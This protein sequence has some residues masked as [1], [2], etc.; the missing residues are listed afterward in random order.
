MDKIAKTSADFLMLF[1]KTGENELDLDALKT[2]K[3]AYKKMRF[4]HKQLKVVICNNTDEG[5]KFL[6]GDF[7]ID[8]FPSIRIINLVGDLP[9]INPND[10][11]FDQNQIEQPKPRY[12]NFK[13]NINEENIIEFLKE[14]DEDSIASEDIPELS[15]ESEDNAEIVEEIESNFF[16]INLL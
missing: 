2:V 15:Q 7:K 16:F 11:N 8:E 3:L 5:C 10:P 6:A 12:F 13:E 1:L 4:V 14:F 9:D